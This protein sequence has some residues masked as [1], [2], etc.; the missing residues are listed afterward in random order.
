MVVFGMSFS[1]SVQNERDFIELLPPPEVSQL[2]NL[3]LDGR[4]EGG[5]CRVCICLWGDIGRGLQARREHCH[6]CFPA[7]GL[8]NIVLYL[9]K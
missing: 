3:K 7:L 6:R 5:C 1:F 9:D 4:E 8:T 2:T